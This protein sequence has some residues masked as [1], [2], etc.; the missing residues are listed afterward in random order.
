M[1]YSAIFAVAAAQDIT[2]LIQLNDCNRAGSVSG[3]SCEP[4]RELLF[5]T[6]MNGDEDL[7]EDITMKGNKFH[8]NQNLAQFATGMNGD[9]DLGEDITMKGNKFHFNQAPESHALF[10]TGMNGDEDLGED[11]TMKGNKFHFNQENQQK[12]A[13]FATGMNG[14]EDLGEDITMK[15]NKFHF[16]QELIQV[17]GDEEGTIHKADWTGYTQPDKVHTL[18]PKIA[19][20]HTAWY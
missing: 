5:A 16:N 3:V 8:F 9:E 7:G 19:K 2:S 14:D 20:T 1:K 4:A 15:G 18:D 6:G 12:L 10:A 11:I 13:Q 17:Q